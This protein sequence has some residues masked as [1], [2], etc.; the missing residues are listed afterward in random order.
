MAT[1]GQLSDS[2]KQLKEL[3]E[4][5][6]VLEIKKNDSPESL[7]ELTVEKDGKKYSF[8][9]KATDLGWWTSDVKSQNGEFKVF[10]DLIEKTFEHYNE[11]G[12][13]GQDLYENC[14]SALKRLIG[15]RCKKCN[16][17]FCASLTAVKNS[18]YG[19]LLTTVEKRKKFAKLLS[20]FY[21]QDRTSTLE[22]FKEMEELE[23][24]EIK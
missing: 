18:E 24:K 10:Q 22:Y 21:V 13:F 8:V 4:G 15:F 20:E 1:E 16:A 12:L 9:L 6:K 2:L 17:E 7:C 23:N 19:D 11:H 14:D 3:L 5:A